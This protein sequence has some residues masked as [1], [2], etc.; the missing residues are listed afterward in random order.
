MASK[1]RGKWDYCSRGGVR[2]STCLWGIYLMYSMHECST[3]L[4]QIQLSVM[5]DY[6]FHDALA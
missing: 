4:Q 5:S 3:S 1:Q 2:A 6:Q